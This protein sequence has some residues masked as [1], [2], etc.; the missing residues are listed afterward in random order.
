MTTFVIFPFA[1]TGWV[2]VTV[3]I[4]LLRVVVVLLRNIHSQPAAQRRP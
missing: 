1:A 3:A 2:F 4:L